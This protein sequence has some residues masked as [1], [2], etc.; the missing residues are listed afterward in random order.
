AGVAQPEEINGIQ[1]KPIQG[2]SMVY[3]F[4]KENAKA[5]STHKTQYFEMIANRGIYSD[6]WYANTVPPHGPWILNAEF[7]PIDQYE[8]ELYNLKEYYS[9]KNNIDEQ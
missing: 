1:R 3:T 9:Q 5:P 8:W 7:P 6:G 2:T 4:K